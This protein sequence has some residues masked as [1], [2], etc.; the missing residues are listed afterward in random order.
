MQSKEALIIFVKNPV[1]G[2]V[3]TRIAKTIGDEMALEIYEELL[4]HT[5]EITAKTSQKKY[6]FYAD[7][8]NQHDAWASLNFEQNLQESNP[9]LGVKMACAFRD[10][11]KAGHEKVCIIGSDSFDL[12]EIIIQQ[13]FDYLIDSK[14]VIGEAKDGGYYL[15]GFNF[16]AIGEQCAEVLT[17]V[18]YDKKWSHATV[19]AEAIQAFEALKLSFA[20]LPILADIDEYEDYLIA[21][22]F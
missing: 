1:L 17:Q 12:D 9:D 16:K 6:V 21:K 7:F 20:Q 5:Q 8:I 11:L 19:A 2:K 4:L 13:S 15:I 22:V 10:L 14:A 18:F 3:K